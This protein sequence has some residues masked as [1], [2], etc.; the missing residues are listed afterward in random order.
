MLERQL[1]AEVG[2]LRKVLLDFIVERQRA[3]LG[4]QQDGERRELFRARADVEARGSGI[5]GDAVLEV[6]CPIGLAVDEPAAVHHPHGRASGVGGVEVGK[7]R[8]DARLGWRVRR[9]VGRRAPRLG[10]PAAVG[11]GRPLRLLGV[12]LVHDGPAAAVLQQHEVVDERPRSVL[13][14]DLDFGDRNVVLVVD[15]ENAARF[16]G[17]LAGLGVGDVVGARPDPQLVV[18]DRVQIQI[19][20]KGAAQAIGLAVR[21]TLDVVGQRRSDVP[22]FAGRILRCRLRTL[23]SV[24]RHGVGCELPMGGEGRGE[25]PRDRAILHEQHRCAVLRSAS[26][27]LCRSASFFGATDRARP[28]R[29]A[30]SG[31]SPSLPRGSAGSSRAASWRG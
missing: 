13:R 29:P 2:Q 9:R 22:Q 26:G 24:E 4:E 5:D 3:P 18:A 15:R 25:E 28:G 14:C 21:R 23:R 12:H 19:G 10:S 6:G 8:I 20:V 1:V 11:G 16:P 31:A 27:I 30:S 7:Q 17:R